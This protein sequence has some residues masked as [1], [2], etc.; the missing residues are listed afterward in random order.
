MKQIGIVKNVKGK[1]AEIRV[2]TEEECK[3]CPL[4]D[5]CNSSSL[6]Q[7]GQATIIVKNDVDAEKNDLV[8]FEMNESD[9]LRGMFTIYIIPFLFFIAGVTVGIVLEK[10]FGIS[11]SNLKNVLPVITSII[12]LGIGIIIVREKDKKH[13]TS[14]Y[15]IEVIAKGNDT[16]FLENLKAP[17]FSKKSN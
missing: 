9:I 12:F 7:N 3:S 11:I 2:A 4:V 5:V 1:F 14:S 15:I 17:D 10:S 8:A 6:L 16:L 13:K